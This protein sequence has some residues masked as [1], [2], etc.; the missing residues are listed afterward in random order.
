MKDYHNDCPN[1]PEEQEWRLGPARVLS[2]AGIPC[3]VYREDALCFAHSVPTLSFN[4]HLVVA[5]EDQ[6][7][8]SAELICALGLQIF[9]GTHDHLNELIVMDPDRTRVFMNST[10]LQQIVTDTTLE[11]RR[12]F[13]LVHPQSHF[14]IDVSDYTRSI[15]L[16]P[17]PDNIRFPTRTAF[18]DSLYD[19]Y[20]DP[21]C[22]R[23]TSRGCTILQTWIYYIFEFTLPEIAVLPNGDLEP[24][25]AE[26]KSSLKPEN[27][28]IFDKGAR[29]NVKSF[30]RDLGLEM[31]KE[32]FRKMGY[33]YVHLLSDSASLSF[34][35]G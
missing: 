34:S 4:Y 32:V 31:R 33:V 9:T 27:Q 30:A 13:I 11:P 20:L 6:E 17:F 29:G 18:L 19:T 10:H 3:L 2:K 26:L 14:N 7:R 5:D 15:S 12:N 35:F 1:S 22:G 24:E 28:P 16:P 23:V 25:Y 21:N 8:A